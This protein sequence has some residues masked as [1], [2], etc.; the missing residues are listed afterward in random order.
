MGV[1][2]EQYHVCIGIHN[3]FVKTKAALKFDGII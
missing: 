3:N 1:T 2:I